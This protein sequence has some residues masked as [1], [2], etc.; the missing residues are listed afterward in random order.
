MTKSTSPKE[1][2]MLA[3]NILLSIRL[4]GVELTPIFSLM[5]GRQGHSGLDFAR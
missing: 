5:N 1:I 4:R 3:S 2:P